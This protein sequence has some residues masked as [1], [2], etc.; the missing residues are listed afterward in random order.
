MIYYYYFVGRKSKIKNVFTYFDNWTM[1]KE[2]KQ[3]NGNIL[4]II[5]TLIQTIQN[6]NHFKIL[7]TR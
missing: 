7:P 3:V 1:A 6:K 2:A 4:S 5:L